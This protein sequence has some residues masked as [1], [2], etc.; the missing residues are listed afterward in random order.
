MQVAE[1]LPELLEDIQYQLLELLSLVLSKRP[2]NSATTQVRQALWAG[3]E[4]PTKRIVVLSGDCQKD[5]CLLGC[6]DQLMGPK[7]RCCCSPSSKP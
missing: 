7:L 5:I 2:F 6:V 4:L 3:G 1:A